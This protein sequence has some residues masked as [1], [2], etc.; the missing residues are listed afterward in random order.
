MARNYPKN[1]KPSLSYFDDYP[2]IKG[3]FESGLYTRK[4]I[5][6]KLDIPYHTICKVL[7]DYGLCEKKLKKEK[8]NLDFWSN[9]FTG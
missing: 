9:D 6:E 3:L 5:A 4:E 1:R 7:R 8:R 2:T